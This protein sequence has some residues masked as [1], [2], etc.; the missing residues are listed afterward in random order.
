[1]T[2]SALKET[3]DVSPQLQKKI[4]Q[5]FHDREFEDFPLDDGRENLEMMEKKRAEE[6]F[7]RAF[8]RRLWWKLLPEDRAEIRSAVAQSDP[9]SSSSDMVDL[10]CIEE[11]KKMSSLA[12]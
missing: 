5:L 3:I 8:F 11:I 12:Q 10:Y 9:Y 2:R 7:R 1:M 4:A 6:A